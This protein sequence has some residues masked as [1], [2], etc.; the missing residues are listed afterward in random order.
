MVMMT[1]TTSEENGDEVTKRD[2]REIRKPERRDLGQEEEEEE[3]EEESGSSLLQPQRQP[4]FPPLFSPPQCYSI[5]PSI[6]LSIY[7]HSSSPVLATGFQSQTNE[8]MTDNTARNGGKRKSVSYLRLDRGPILPPPF[9]PGGPLA[10]YY[11][12]IITSSPHFLNVDISTPW[13]P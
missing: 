2:R 4:S 5:H 7:S 1:T 10:L 11:H 12:H 13:V 9:P 6:H 3:E 8:E